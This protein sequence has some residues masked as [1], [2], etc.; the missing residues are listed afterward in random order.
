ML[1]VAVLGPVEI[2][3]EG[4]PHAVRP[5]KTTEVLVRLALEAGELVRTERLIEDLWGDSGGT[6]RRNTLQTKVSSLRRALA[7]VARVEGSDAGYTLWV[8]REEVDAFAVLSLAAEVTARRAAGELAEAAEASARALALF[9][10]DLLRGAGDGSWTLAH[11]ARYGEVRM[12]LIEARLATLV[13]A[14]LAADVIGELEALVIEHP[15]R[16]GLW[17]SLMRALYQSG[18]QADAL[19]TYRRV[20]TQ[21]SEELGLDPGSELQAL[22]QQVLLQAPELG[23][24]VDQRPPSHVAGPPRYGNLPSLLS[25]IDGRDGDVAAVEALLSAD[26]LVTVAGPAGVGK[27]RLAIEVAR[28]HRAGEAWLVRLETATTVRAVLDRVTD[29][30]GLVKG[31]DHQI[32]D[33]LRSRHALIV[34]DNCEQ[35]PQPIGAVASKLL[36]AAPE[37]RV[38]ATSQVPLSLAGEVLHS[39]AP[40]TQETSVLLFTRLARAQQRAFVLDEESG[41]LVAEVCQALDG[42]PLAIEL[43]AARTKALPIEEIARRLN[44]RFQLL[45]DPLQARPPRHRALSAAISW[46]Y[47]LLFPDDQRGL[48]ALSCFTGG[49]DLAAVEQVLQ[50]LGVPVDAALDVVARLV[51]RSLVSVVGDHGK[52]RYRLL[53]SVAA[54]ARERMADAGSANAGRNAHAR[55]VADAA[56]AAATGLRSGEQGLHLAFLREERANIDAALEWTAAH[57]PLVGLAIANGFGWGWFITGDGAAGATRLRRALDAAA[58]APPSDRA[59]NLALRAWMQASNDIAVAEADADAAITAASSSG[60]AAILATCQTALAF[61]L[62]QRTRPRSALAVLEGCTS[63]QAAAGRAWEE[64]SAWMLIAHASVAIGDLDAARGAAARVEPLVTG[65]GDD[66]AMSHFE[67]LVGLLAES[68]RDFDTA[69]SHF[70]EAAA[71]S[72]RLGFH[73]AAGF[74][75]ASLGRAL[76]Q[77]GHVPRSIG[78]LEEAVEIGRGARDLRVVAV[79]RTRLARSLRQAGDEAAAAEAAHAAD[80]WFRSAGGGDGSAMASYLVA[81]LTAGADASAGRRLLEQSLADAKREGDRALVVLVMDAQARQLANSGDAIAGAALLAQADAV[82]VAGGVSDGERVDANV[83][84]RVLATGSASPR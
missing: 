67:N 53:H 78:V 57:D 56:G 31:P 81:A 59:T 36:D 41:A 69:A 60:D 50:A 45:A 73:A 28:Q 48:W 72:V 33:Q 71:A 38:L 58:V 3:R 11:R 23:A 39:L 12:S 51:D 66:W 63:A 4:T 18:R 61:V 49:A 84:R 25:H 29:A 10:G 77:G 14:G 20:R 9:R 1:T 22:E 80:H 21:M 70:E 75:L 79:A 32:L 2:L 6:A 68:E 44:D 5:G 8:P 24:P 76:Q 30:L 52:V 54:F 13:A 55:W 35:A 47:D 62:L 83:A 27:T 40:L 7:G 15:L 42:L 26:R 46:S 16:E 74:H 19:A 37:V 82:A 34:F 17:A 43:A 65:T 64:R